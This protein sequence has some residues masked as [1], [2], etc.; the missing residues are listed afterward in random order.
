MTRTRVYTDQALAPGQPVELDEAASH[1]LTGVMRLRVG[2]PL[3]LFDGRGTECQGVI[4]RIGKRR[5][6]VSLQTHDPVSRE[7]PLQVTLAQGISRGERMDYTIQKAVELG[8]TAIAPLTTLRSTVK[9]DA[10][11]TEKRLAHWHKVIVSACEQ[12][13]RNH[14]PRLLPVQGLQQWLDR[15]ENGSKIVLRGGAETALSALTPPH[16]TVTMLI[17]P[18]G[19]LDPVEL[20]SAARAGYLPV[21]L[22]PRILRTETAAV[23]AL[24]AMQALWGDFR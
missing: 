22:G 11:R 16:N 23:A 19:G 13:G 8:V 6:A 7:S 2:D 18:E 24:A 10:D 9:L 3:V 21:R 1:H 5:V 20:E 4:E 12:C 15:P 17:G 14:L